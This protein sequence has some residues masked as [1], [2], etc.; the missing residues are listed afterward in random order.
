MKKIIQT[1][2]S[3]FLWVMIGTWVEFFILFIPLCVF[4]FV[5]MT[6][7]YFENWKIILHIYT[8]KDIVKEAK[9]KENFMI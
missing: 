9:A 4:K 2:N 1:V 6:I 3:A 5:L 7:C 8:E